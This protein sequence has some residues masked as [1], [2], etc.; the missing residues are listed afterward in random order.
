M[1]EEERKERFINLLSQLLSDYGGIKIQLAEKLNI[2][3]PTLTRWFQGKVDPATLD[4]AVFA[5][6]AE[7]S[8]RSIDDLAYFL[9]IIQKT[10]DEILDNFKN[11]IQ[12]LLS[13]QSQDSLAKKLGI[14]NTAVAG[15]VRSQRKVDPRRIA[16]STVAGLAQEKA[17]TIERLLIYLGLKEIETENNL[18][19]RLQSGAAILSLKDRVKLLAWLSDLIQQEIIEKPDISIQNQE[20]LIPPSA[21]TFCTFDQSLCA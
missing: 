1:N 13:T 11:F 18:F 4:L 17:W 15:W 10:E 14:N 8:N 9:G 20:L 3:P 12:D 19:F 16:I 5:R 21:R 2:K 6:I 7:V